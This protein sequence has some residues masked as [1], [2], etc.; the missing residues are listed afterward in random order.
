MDAKELAKIGDQW[1][2]A[3]EKRL[4]AD[5]IAKALKDKEQELEAI[6]INNLSKG[7]ASGISGKLVTVYVDVVEV[8]KLEDRDKFMAYVWKHKAWELI[9]TTV[10]KAPWRER[11]DDGA[12]IPG[13]SSVFVPKLYHSKK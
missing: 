4:A 8:P 13:L 1:L 7:A 2:K 5:K 6:L 11:V 12:K 3:R 9:P 10:N